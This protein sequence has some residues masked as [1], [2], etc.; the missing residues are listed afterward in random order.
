MGMI[1][2]IAWKMDHI[3]LGDVDGNLNFWNLK[4]KNC[5]RVQ[6]H[7][8]CIKK[9]KFAPGRGNMKIFVL[10]NDGADLWDAKEV[11]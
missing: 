9:I 4:K 3:I 7:R 10:Y 2:C 1:S 5:R 11:G 8:G 6:S